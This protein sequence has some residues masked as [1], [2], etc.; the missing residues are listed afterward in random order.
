MTDGAKKVDAARRAW[1][2]AV[3]QRAFRTVDAPDFI[4]EAVMRAEMDP[5][6]AHLDE[7]LEK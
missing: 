3:A 2:K 6:H 5:R 7:L 4:V 1:R